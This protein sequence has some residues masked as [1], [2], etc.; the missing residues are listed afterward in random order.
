MKK[1]ETILIIIILALYF[2]GLASLPLGE[3]RPED[4]KATMEIMEFGE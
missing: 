4:V 1:L 2:L 3:P